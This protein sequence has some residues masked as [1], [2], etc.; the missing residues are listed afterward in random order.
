MTRPNTLLVT[1][2]FFPVWG[3]VPPHSPPPP[4]PPHLPHHPSRPHL[5]PHP[6]PT[7]P[8]PSPTHPR[9]LLFVALWIAAS[10]VLVP[11]D[12][13]PSVVSLLALIFLA[14]LPPHLF[15]GLLPTRTV[16]AFM[17]D[18]VSR[19]LQFSLKWQNQRAFSPHRTYLFAY[20]PH[21]LLP[22]GMNCAF[23]HMS[24][25]WASVRPICG[26][27]HMLASSAVLAVPVIKHFWWASGLRD[28][29]RGTLDRLLGGDGS[30]SSSSTTAS[31]TASTT[32]SSSAPRASCVLVP[33]GVQECLRMANGRETIYLRRR[34]GF[35]RAA[36]RAGAE[37]VPCFCFG[38]T[39]AM[40]FLS[41]TTI[42]DDDDDDDDEHE[43]HHHLT[44]KKEP[45]SPTPSPAPSSETTRRRRPSSHSSPNPPPPP[46]LNP[47]P[48]SSSA[49]TAH[50]PTSRRWL[51]PTIRRLG[52]ETLEVVSRHLGFVPLLFWGRWGLP[53][54]LP[55]SLPERPA[56]TCVIG[57]PMV[58][59]YHTNP[60]HELVEKT[61][62]K[63]IDNLEA[64]IDQY[65][66]ECGYP[67]LSVTIL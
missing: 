49:T 25:A 21:S 2:C 43:H 14:L 58:V 42:F 45:D 56:M 12:P 29:S 34:T 19:Y 62:T 51:S 41:P 47:R 55:P 53:I 60:S 64:L 30:S 5:T 33:G 48:R 38:Q 6:A 28:I 50:P 63:F 24:P 1:F 15:A 7:H 10:V 17:I 3:Y 31:T 23:N 22:W 54:P 16:V 26:P 11:W 57:T 61:L 67:H 66:A 59:G 65:K 44:V 39:D 8:F 18:T 35:I 27:V 4:S 20:E 13:L 52:R 46:P 40:H 32:S 36:M 9:R 37:V